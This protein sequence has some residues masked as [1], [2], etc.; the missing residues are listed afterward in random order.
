ML[1]YSYKIWHSEEHKCALKPESDR[2]LDEDEVRIVYENLEA[3]VLLSYDHEPAFRVSF[4]SP[5][6]CAQGVII[7]VSTALDEDEADRSIVRCLVRINRLDIGLCFIA[8][9]LKLAAA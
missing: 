5:Q 9:P 3:L 8:E 7:V 2:V 1:R 4:L 6:A